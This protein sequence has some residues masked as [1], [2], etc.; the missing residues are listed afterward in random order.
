MP[1]YF[2]RIAYDGTNYRGY[3]WQPGGVPTVQAAIEKTL[4]QI[5]KT[6][7]RFNGCG[8]TDAGV[9]ATQYYGH[10]NLETAPPDNYL[11]ILNKQLP[12]GISVHD[13]FAVQENAHARYDAFERTYDYIFHGTRNA[14]L[15]RYS[16]LL[17]LTNFAP[18]T[19]Q[20][21]LNQLV[22]EHDFYAF[23]K[24]PD[25][26]NT[27]RCTITEARLYAN[28][29]GT[30]YRIRFVANRF[31]RGMIRILAREVIDVGLGLQT[32]Q[33]VLEKLETGE[34]DGVIKQAPAPG[35]FL[36]GVRYEYA[37][38]EAEL[39]AIHSG[40]WREIV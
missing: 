8:R 14:L 12:R 19:T 40:P 33:E 26:H 27:T 7:V 38:R 2:L 23:C 29:N 11:F 31:L 25:Q 24:S 13:Y 3:Q 17:P 18:A 16:S 32:T 28:E 15:E 4:S 6:P 35:L 5:H 36:T 20:Q 34:R 9:H 30:T 22:G 21:I 10:F 37:N 39:P 1:D